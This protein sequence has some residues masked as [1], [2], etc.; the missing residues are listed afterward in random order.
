MP[1]KKAV[2]QIVDLSGE[3]FSMQTV[4]NSPKKKYEKQKDKDKSNDEMNN[5]E[6]IE[7]NNEISEEKPKKRVK[8]HTKK[9]KVDHQKEN[10]EN[11]DKDNNKEI[12]GKNQQNQE[13]QENQ[14]DQ[15]ND[16]EMN[17]ENVDDS[18]KVKSKKIP[19]K[20][21]K[22]INEENNDQDPK[23]DKDDKDDKEVKKEK[24]VVLKASQSKRKKK[25]TFICSSY[26]ISD[27]V[28]NSMF[29]AENNENIIMHLNLKPD[30]MKEDDVF[31]YDFYKENNK[32]RTETANQNP[33]HQEK[34][35][36]KEMDQPIEG[37]SFENVHSRLSDQYEIYDHAFL[38][39]PISDDNETKEENK[40]VN[41]LKDFR[42]ENKE[43]PSNTN[44][45]CFYCCHR[46]FNEPFGI[47]LRYRDDGKFDVFG[48]FCTLECAQSYNFSQQNEIDE[49]WE[50]SNLINF[51]AR[52]IN[53]NKQ[54]FVKPAPNRL[55]LK[56]F[57]G[58]LS[59]EEFRSAC[60]KDKVVHINS[61]PMV[62]VSHQIEEINETEINNDLKFI[63]INVDRIN[64]YKEKMR[65][66][67]SKPLYDAKNTLDNA[68]NIKITSRSS[69]NR[70]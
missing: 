68:I 62:I 56:L 39:K 55:S 49:M 60:H 17:K 65:L 11:E 19:K 26:N 37:Y 20:I 61:Y 67:R 34:E 66:K 32:N 6:S 24:N 63:P 8:R 28:D 69:S 10:L 58:H 15:E 33:T 53:Y 40:V 16:E 35:K 52:K 21:L 44:V 5:R 9:T 47:P 12:E 3:N 31:G 70:T 42:D 45:S 59:I 23:D 22:K 46:F 30:A 41:L 54:G 25:N 43:W 36:D 29:G 1:K 4:I 57:G 18:A 50:R 27:D 51:L 13:H 64:K 7:M 38:E 48:C 2:Q 14:E